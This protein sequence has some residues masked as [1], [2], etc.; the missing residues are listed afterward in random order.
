[1]KHPTRAFLD[2]CSRLPFALGAAAAL[3][4]ATACGGGADGS[5]DG[6]RDAPSTLPARPDTPSETPAPMTTSDDVGSAAAD[7][8]PSE[9]GD[10]AENAAGEGLV[11]PAPSFD[12]II[13]T[14]FGGYYP[15][16]SDDEECNTFSHEN[17]FT[18]NQQSGSLRWSW[19]RTGELLE[20]TRTLDGADRTR[21]LDAY[22]S[23]GRATGTCGSDDPFGWLDV[24]SDGAR[25]RFAPATMSCYRGF[26]NEAYVDQFGFFGLLYSFQE[27]SD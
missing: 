2:P 16:A 5:D 8:E 1:M 14:S 23:I 4:A 18:F 21:V 7:P 25:S 12:E 15:Q 13:V 17:R 24:R 11:G 26:E 10:A 9:A 19:C 6:S 22:S 27:L 20:G 3:L